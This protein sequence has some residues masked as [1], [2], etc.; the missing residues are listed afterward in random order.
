MREPAERLRSLEQLRYV[1]SVR[2]NTWNRILDVYPDELRQTIGD[3]PW[4][5]DPF[6][7]AEREWLGNSTPEQRH[8]H[9]GDLELKVVALGKDELEISGIFGRETLY[10]CSPSPRLRATITPSS[11]STL[12]ASSSRAAGS[13]RTWRASTF[14]TSPP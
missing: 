14:G 10:I 5:Y 1:L 7:S 12:T 13:P 8:V 2:T 11:A 4:E 9:Y 3:T 6:A